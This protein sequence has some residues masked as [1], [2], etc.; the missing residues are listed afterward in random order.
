MGVI[1]DTH[2]HIELREFLPEEVMKAYLD[3]LNI[4]KSMV[5]WG[6]EEDYVWPHYKVGAEEILAT[7]DAGGVDKCVALPL[8][9]GL[10]GEVKKGV[11]EYNEW[12]FE[13]CSTTDRIIPFMG[14]DPS[15]RDAVEILEDL[16]RKHDP[17]GVKV[18]PATG[19][20]PY[21]ERLEAF[22][23]AVDDHGLIAVTH[24]GAAWGPLADHYCHPIFF[25]E[26]AER[27][28]DAVF[29]IAHLGG[30][31]R[32]EMYDLIERLDNV[33]ADCSAL[34]GWLPGSPEMAI[35]RLKEMA[36]RIPDRALFGSDFPLF[37]W[38]YSTQQWVRFVL[39]SDWGNEA[40][41]EKVL[42]GNARRILGV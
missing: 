16:T 42:S 6:I 31:W 23:K 29:I 7:M 19:W 27:Y 8:D 1:I 35:A 36:E 15:R 38:N 14:I 18:Y 10:I 41:K 3:G 34:Q 17:K 9:F 4:L 30:K 26:V 25:Q 20:Y 33:Y 32:S 28:E 2:V 39:D 11:R 13:Q 24:A 12:A 22:W 40:V 37:E 5:D 21:W